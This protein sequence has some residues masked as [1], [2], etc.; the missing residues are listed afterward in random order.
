MMTTTA[1]KTIV[2]TTDLVHDDPTSFQHSIALARA[3]GARLVSLHANAPASAAERMPE[4]AEILRAWGAPVSDVEFSKQVHSCCDDPVDTI[5]DALRHIKPDLIVSAT[6][7]KSALARIFAG[8][9]A[10]A[11][12]RNATA[13]VL[14]LPAEPRGFVDKATGKIDLQRVLVPIGDARAAV[15]ALRT[16]A[17]FAEIAGAQTVEFT[18]VHVGQPV[19]VTTQW[20]TAREGWTVRHHNV[21]RDVE[22]AILE[23]AQNSCVVVMAT[24]GHDSVGDVIR[25]SHT[26][27]VLHRTHCPLLAVGV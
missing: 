22:D 19:D 23:H 10:E 18:L 24:R 11:I 17:S 3:S 8:S 2:H 4:A 14:L 1:T 13:P 16:A 25:G 26:D 9:S 7:K 20:L 27:R 15:V 12:A 6:H 21:D 5:L